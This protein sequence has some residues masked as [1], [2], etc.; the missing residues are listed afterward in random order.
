STTLTLANDNFQHK[1]RGARMR[2]FKTI[3]DRYNTTQIV[4]AHHLDDQVETIL[5]RIIRGSAFQGYS[6]MTSL[7]QE[8]G[9]TFIRPLLNTPKTMIAAYAKE[10]KITYFND[11]T[12][13]EMIYTRNRLRHKIIPLIEAENPKYREKFQ[14]LSDYIEMANDMIEPTINTFIETHYENQT[15]P[16]EAFNQLYPLQKI[17]VL[18]HLINDITNNTIEVSY[19]QYMEMIA[20]CLNQTPNQS[21]TLNQTYQFVTSY[22]TIT[23]SKTTETPSIYLKITTPGCYQVTDNQGFIITDNKID[24]KHRNYFELWYNELVFPLYLRTRQNGDRIVLNV[25]TKKIKDVLIDQK[26]SLKKRDTLVLLANDTHVLWIPGIK[27]AHQD[28]SK[29]NKLYIYEVTKC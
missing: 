9:Y 7:Y 20:L 26:I 29:P 8:D 11:H 22:D 13:Q 6:G 21:L 27:T 14:Q 10:N 24:Q 16:I 1:A 25:G 19:E 12:N 5:M 2:F 15:F 23:V 4:L 17:S 28:Q 18:Q 3:A